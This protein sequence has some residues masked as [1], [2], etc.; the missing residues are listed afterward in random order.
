[1]IMMMIL[2]ASEGGVAAAVAVV[3]VLVDVAVVAFAC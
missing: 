3:D 2:S 1:M